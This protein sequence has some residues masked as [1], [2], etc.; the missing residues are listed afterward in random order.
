MSQLL[1]GM[2][3]LLSVGIKFICLNLGFLPAFKLPVQ[4]IVPT[5]ETLGF[6][7]NEVTEDFK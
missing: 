2:V 7:T 6:V 4:L 5:K 1:L 3:Q